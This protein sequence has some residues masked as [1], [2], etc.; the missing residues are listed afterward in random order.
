MGLQRGLDTPNF[1]WTT[2][3]LTIYGET[4]RNIVLPAP[5]VTYYIVNIS[6][7]KKLHNCIFGLKSNP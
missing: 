1:A 4:K 2:A 5:L 7:A 3:F 6:K